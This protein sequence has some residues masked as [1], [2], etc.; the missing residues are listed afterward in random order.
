MNLEELRTLHKSV[1]PFSLR[2]SRLCV[3]FFSSLAR[4]CQDLATRVL[5]RNL[6]SGFCGVSPRCVNQLP[7][8][9]TPDFCPVKP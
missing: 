3:E 4:E 5:I 7:K 2:P 1:I 8:N 9:Y 6:D